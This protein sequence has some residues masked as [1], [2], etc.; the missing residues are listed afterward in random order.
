[1]R[2]RTTKRACI[3]AA[4]AALAASTLARAQ[5]QP[6]FRSGTSVVEINVVVRDRDGKFVRGLT[7]DDFEILEENEPRRIESMY[8]VTAPDA[9]GRAADAAGT[10]RLAPRTFVFAFDVDQ[11]SP[12]SLTRAR[13]AAVAF[14]KERLVPNDFSALAALGGSS[15]GRISQ[16]RKALLALLDNLK[17]SSAAVSRERSLREW[18]RVLSFNE[19]AEIVNGNTRALT[20]ARDRACKEASE[21]GESMDCTDPGMRPGAGAQPPGEK[22]IPGISQE[23]NREAI[24]QQ[25]RQ[26]SIAYVSETR[27]VALRSIAALESLASAVE[28]LRGRKTIVWFTEGTPILEAASQAREAAARAA[29]SGVA[30]YTI[31]PRGLQSRGA[32]VNEVGAQELGHDVFSDTGDLPALM[33]SGTGGLFIRN[34]NRLDR[35][36]AQIEDDTSNYYVIGY[37]AAA[38]SDRGQR[39]L[40]VRVR[41]QGVDARVRH[42]FMAPQHALTTAGAMVAAAVSAL[43]GTRGALSTPTVATPSPSTV[44]TEATPTHV[45]TTENVVKLRASDGS[46]SSDLAARAWAAYERGN[47]EA[48]LP[49]FEKAAARDD[50]RPWALYAMGFTYVGVGRPRDALNAWERVRA[51]EPDFIPVYLDLASHYAQQ[52]DVTEAIAV[53]REA[54]TRWPRE[55]DVHN[56][57]GVL[58][59]RRNVLDEAIAS[60]LKA[61][62]AE[63]DDA[64]S[65]LNLGRAYEMRYDRAR[66]YDKHLLKWVGPEGDR[67]KARAA[68]ERAV[69]LGGP[70]GQ[71]AADA[72]ARMNWSA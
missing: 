1:M 40:T 60:F 61:T 44:T 7:A 38:T 16:D 71:Q 19:A 64:L 24:E 17:P 52:S 30:V 58:L 13:D 65:W 28:G 21:G 55:A 33:A 70:Y 37:S 39:R 69:K 47:L 62:S 22:G 45:P 32:G 43:P 68:F 3:L 48:A 66:R 35:A 57:I 59:I 8:A 67:V 54:A 26:K 29:Q 5:Q 63:E 18:P 12:R 34:E 50:V 2:A 15:S 42:G 53:L 20:D 56:G 14:A 23:A 31:D 51:A 36:L 6:I 4:L 49:L 72:L 46:S 9:A 11:M 10:A 27:T 25:L 41:R